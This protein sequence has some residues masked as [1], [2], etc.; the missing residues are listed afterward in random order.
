MR[1]GPAALVWYDG[2]F[3]YTTASPW[4]STNKVSTGWGDQMEAPGSRI[5]R[6]SVARITAPTGPLVPVSTRG[7]TTATYSGPPGSSVNRSEN[8]GA[9]LCQTLETIPATD[10][11]SWLVHP[12][13]LKRTWL[14]GSID[15]KS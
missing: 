10:G 7:I 13:K 5:C 12:L 11:G 9:P 8:A 2:S 15:R 3:R 4:R 14:V 1:I 6:T